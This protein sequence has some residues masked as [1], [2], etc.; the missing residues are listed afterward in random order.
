MLILMFSKKLIW[1][2]H[3]VPTF[4]EDKSSIFIFYWVHF[5]ILSTWIESKSSIDKNI[6]L[7]FFNMLHKIDPSEYCKGYKKS[8]KNYFSFYSFVPK[9]AVNAFDQ[10]KFKHHKVAAFHDLWCFFYLSIL[11][12]HLLW[13]LKMASG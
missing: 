12:L 7:P 1:F 10:L 6:K 2:L 13:A 4:P 8:L 11:C 5:F 3:P 9:M